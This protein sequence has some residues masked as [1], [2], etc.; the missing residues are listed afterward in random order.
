[1]SDEV[2]R[3]A[4]SGKGNG[5]RGTANGQVCP[6][7]VVG[8][9]VPSTMHSASPLP[10]PRSSFPS[11]RSQ[12]PAP[13]MTDPLVASYESVAYDGRAIRLA[14]P[15]PMAAIA[16][17]HGMTPPPPDASRVLELGCATG[18]N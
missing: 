5:E 18:W 13:V 1:M 14:D 3:E 6:S 11:P 2:K 12:V 10:G 16:T 8:E 9:R 17:L 15:D 7:R 4:G